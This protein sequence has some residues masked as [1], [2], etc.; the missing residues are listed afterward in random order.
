MSATLSPS[1]S[2]CRGKRRFD[3]WTEANVSRHPHCI[4]SVKPYRCPGCCGFHLGKKAGSHLRRPVA[5][6]RSIIEAW[7]INWTQGAEA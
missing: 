6:R 2:I 3:T 5:R 7:A 1:N 4:S